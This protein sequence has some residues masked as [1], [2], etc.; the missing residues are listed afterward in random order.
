MIKMDAAGLASGLTGEQFNGDRNRALVRG[1]VFRT[2]EHLQSRVVAAI[3]RSV[4]Q[5]RA[6]GAAE[7]RSFRLRLPLRWFLENDGAPVKM[8][9]KR[10]RRRGPALNQVR[11]EVMAEF[12][13]QHTRLS[14]P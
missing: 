9:V 14:R 7:R 1:T 2:P 3:E 10:R 4:Q 5:G 12:L 13:A 11:E 6:S 8:K